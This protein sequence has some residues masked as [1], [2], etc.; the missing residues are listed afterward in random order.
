MAGDGDDMND[1]EVRFTLRIPSWLRNRLQMQAH[2]SGRSLNGEVVAR[3]MA[4]NEVAEKLDLIIA[5]LGIKE[6]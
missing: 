5:H 2:A 3:L 1:E 6:D 4:R